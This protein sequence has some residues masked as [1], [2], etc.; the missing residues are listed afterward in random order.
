MRTKVRGLL[1][2]HFL[3]KNED[4]FVKPAIR[5]VLPF[6]KEVIVFDTGSTDKTID[7]IKSIKSKK[8]NYSKKETIAQK[9]WL[10]S[11]I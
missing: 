3:V 2:A 8:I 11:E 4:A 6:V 9:S 5:N 10:N 1:T 7:E